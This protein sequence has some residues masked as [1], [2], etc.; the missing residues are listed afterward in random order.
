MRLPPFITVTA[1]FLD[2]AEDWVAEVVRDLRPDCLQF[3]GNETPAFCEAWRSPYIK[4]I[5]MGSIDDP[6]DYAASI[7]MPRAFCSTVTLLD[8][9]A[10]QVIHLTGL[11]SPQ[12]SNIR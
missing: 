4:S 5:P 9:R 11:K 8:V 3:H 1:L 12:L 2:E 10:D 6:S 7:R